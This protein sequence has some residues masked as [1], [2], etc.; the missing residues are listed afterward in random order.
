MCPCVPWDTIRQLT[1]R[2]NGLQ[3]WTPANMTIPGLAK[4]TF[5]QG[6]LRFDSAEPIMR[7]VPKNFLGDPTV[8]TVTGRLARNHEHDVVGHPL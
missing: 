7:V 2:I 6:T 3:A 4:N 1:N 8:F 5:P